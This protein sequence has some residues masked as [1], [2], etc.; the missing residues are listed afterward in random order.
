MQK[1]QT[2]CTNSKNFTVFFSFWLF[3][4]AKTFQLLLAGRNGQFSCRSLT[5]HGLV[6]I[7]MIL[8][9]SSIIKTDILSEFGARR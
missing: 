1:R 3:P 5:Y 9:L 2:L 4:I 8:G 7:M 6:L